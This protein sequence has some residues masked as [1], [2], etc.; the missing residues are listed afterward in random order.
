MPIGSVI[1]KKYFNT[2]LLFLSSIALPVVL[3]GFGLIW[4]KK[5]PLSELEN[6]VLF[7][8]FFP[9]YVGVIVFTV[10]RTYFT[11]K[12]WKYFLLVPLF[13]GIGA[14]LFFPLFLA[15]MF[16][17]GEGNA[18]QI[19]KVF[20]FYLGLVI[21]C[22][23]V[24]ITEFV[25]STRTN[26]PR[27]YS[28]VHIVS[29]FI[30]ILS[31]KFIGNG[32]IRNQVEYAFSPALYGLLMFP[33]A[34]YITRYH[35]PKIRDCLFIAVF[36]ICI[37]WSFFVG[38]GLSKN[39]SLSN[40]IN[41]MNDYFLDFIPA[42]KQQ[43][44]KLLSI[45]IPKNNEV[46]NLGDK[47]FLFPFDTIKYHMRISKEHHSNKVQSIEFYIVPRDFRMFFDVDF[48]NK[49]KKLA[50]NS[51]RVFI[52]ET[53]KNKYRNNVSTCNGFFLLKRATKCNIYLLSEG[54]VINLEYPA[55]LHP[56]R[57]DLV[58][59]VKERLNAWQLKE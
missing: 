40:S 19:I 13:G 22:L 42:S 20:F 33:Y 25:V 30:T 12:Y 24:T 28:L 6:I 48:S 38:V 41:W 15:V 10:I 56:Y 9:L 31:I 45:L 46:I 43:K 57:L 59:G 34:A 21:V 54:L 2:F 39:Y 53:N 37:L 58:E 35:L 52:N 5:L 16:G 4:A 23:P 51:I 14:V 47:F 18:P 8:Q 44:R 11:P 32:S 49:F 36:A 3:A 26:R 1:L 17:I 27:L 55:P 29:L 7:N 50:N